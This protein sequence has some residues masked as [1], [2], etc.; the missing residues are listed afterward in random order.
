MYRLLIL[1]APLLMMACY[2]RVEYIPITNTKI[3]TTYISSYRIDSVLL[4]D[5]VI[6]DRLVKGDTVYINNT[7]IKYRY[8]VQLKTDTLTRI[9]I[10]S[11]ENK[12]A[13]ELYYSAMDSVKEKEKKIESQSD[14][15]KKMTCVIV[16]IIISFILFFG[17]KKFVSS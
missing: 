2:N 6:I 17:Y 11:A 7:S 1:I 4:R 14:I 15:I 16:C 8:R 3:D 12:K 10:D 5:S 9:V 13:M